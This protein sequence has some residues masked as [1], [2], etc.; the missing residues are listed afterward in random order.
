[1]IKEIK[2]IVKN[3]VIAITPNSLVEKG[4]ESIDVS[5]EYDWNTQIHCD[6]CKFG[7]SVSTRLKT[8]GNGD[9][10]PDSYGD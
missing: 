4:I 2:K 1:M 9:R 10:S 3:L 8:G 7:T 5:D 6:I